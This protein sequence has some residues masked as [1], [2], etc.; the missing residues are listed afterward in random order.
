MGNFDINLLK[1]YTEE[2]SAD[3]LDSMY[4]SLLLPYI[5]TP[6]RVTPRSKTLIDNIFSNNIKDGSISGNIV[7]TISDHYTQ[8]LLLQNLNDKNPTKSEI[9]HQDFKKLNR[10]N[11]ESDLVNTNWDAILEVNN[12]DADK[13]FEFFVTTVNSVNA[14]HAPLKNIFVKERNLR[15]KH[16]ITKGILTSINNKNKTYRKYCRAK[17]QTRRDELRKLFRNTITNTLI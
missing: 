2:D 4:A 16:W 11:L 14:E 7:T 13:S 10:N 15:G 5:S 6:S 9:Y 3:V 8:F 1:Y 17:S 12:D